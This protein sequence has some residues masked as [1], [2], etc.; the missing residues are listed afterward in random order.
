LEK[1]RGNARIE[2]ICGIRALRRSRRDYQILAELAKQNAVAPEKLVESFSSVRQ[3]LLDGEREREKLKAQVARLEAEASYRT[4]PVSA[5]GLR[6]LFLRT[7]VLDESSRL[8]ATAFAENPKAICVI[9]ADE[10]PSV[11]IACSA[12]SGVN[13]GAVLK[14]ILAEKGGRGGGSATLAQAKLPDNSAIA[15]VQDVLGFTAY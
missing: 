6:R 5:D 11:L 3:R 1:L 8:A 7:P 15:A 13:V 10:P 4:T 14:Q 12:D 9:A 2:F